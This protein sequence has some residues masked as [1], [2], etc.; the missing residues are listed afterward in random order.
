MAWLAHRGKKRPI[1]GAWSFEPMGRRNWFLPLWH[2]DDLPPVKV[3]DVP[4]PE[5]MN[6][7]EVLREG[8]PEFQIS[9]T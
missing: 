5:L 4:E 9:R 8:I 7:K 1:A 2:V 3:V 6:L